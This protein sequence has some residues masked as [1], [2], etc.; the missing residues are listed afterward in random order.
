MGQDEGRLFVPQLHKQNIKEGINYKD[1]LLF[2]V[3][4]LQC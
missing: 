1:I 4:Y 2:L 3:T